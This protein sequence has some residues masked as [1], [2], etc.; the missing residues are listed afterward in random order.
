M[1]QMLA[2][3]FW[4]WIYH[5]LFIAYLF[6]LLCFLLITVSYLCIHIFMFY[7]VSHLCTFFFV[8]MLILLY[9]FLWWSCFFLIHFYFI[10]LYLYYPAFFMTALHCVKFF[11]VLTDRKSIPFVNCQIQRC[12]HRPTWWAFVSGSEQLSAVLLSNEHS[13]WSMV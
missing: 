8:F 7:S 5:K 13:P 2:S 4:F 1:L 11:L 3:R 12:R 10:F 6:S 9:I